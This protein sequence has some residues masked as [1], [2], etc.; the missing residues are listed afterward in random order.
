M[1]EKAKAANELNR[2]LSNA[3]IV[4]GAAE[5]VAV[6]NRASSGV[7][8][9]LD[10]YTINKLGIEPVYVSVRPEE[11]KRMWNTACTIT[12][13]DGKVWHVKVP[14]F[15]VFGIADEN[16]Y[17]FRSEEATRPTKKLAANLAAYTVAKQLQLLK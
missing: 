17:A 16:L 2:A 11:N 4:N 6:D 12:Q 3:D 5:G 9:A 13:Q 1:I 10:L 15:E 7:K 8:C 14:H